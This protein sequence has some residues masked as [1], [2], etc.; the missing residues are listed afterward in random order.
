MGMRRL[1]ILLVLAVAAGC[2]AAPKP[3]ALPPLAGGDTAEA[4]LR[5]AAKASGDPWGT[6][7]TVEVSYRGEWGSLVQKL[8]PTLVDARFRK[9]S[10]ETYTPSTARVVQIHRGPDGIKSV[11]R[12]PGSI[13]VAYNGEPSRD[14]EVL[15]SSALVA[16]AYTIFLFGASWLAQNA[17]NPE[18]V[19][20]REF[21]GENCWVIQGTLRPGFGPSHEDQFLAWIGK[22][23]LR[24][25]RFQFTLEGLE[26]TRGADV[27]V[28]FSKFV[29]TPGG[30]LFPTHFVE[31]VRRPIP[32]LAHTWDLVRLSID[33][34]KV[35]LPER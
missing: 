17:E 15:A 12:S 31:Y 18:I 32:T 21:S 10:D 2:T 5:S 28:I 19:D 25:H 13:S 35:E 26:S 4:I 6:S 30:Y 24:L 22:E 34:R 29:E 3:G 1:G 23:S 7:S 33:G 14:E 27:D 20:Q 11:V 8:Q 16:D 9:E